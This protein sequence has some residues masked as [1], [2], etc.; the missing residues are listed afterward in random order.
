MKKQ[1]ISLAALLMSALCLGACTSDTPSASGDSSTGTDNQEQQTLVVW[2]RGTADAMEGKCF[3]SD[4]E[5]FQKEHENVTVEHLILST[6]DQVAKWNTAFASGTDPDVMDIGVSHIVSR[7][8]LGQITPLD[9]FFENW[10][11]KDNLL[12]SMVEYGRYDD[13]IYSLAYN[14]SPSVMA[15]RKDYFEAAG[16]DPEKAPKDWAE[17]LEYCEALTIYDGDVMKQGAV[18]LPSTYNSTILWQFMIQNNAETLTYENNTPDFNQE[19]VIEAFQFLSDIVP[20][21]MLGEKDN[22]F[23]T[24]VNGQTAMCLQIAPATIISM[25]E[26]DPSLKDK[27][28]YQAS[29]TNKEGGIHCGAWTYA[30]TERC[31]NKDLAWS[32]IDFV[33][34]EERCTARM[35]EQGMV[36]PLASLQDV[37]QEFGGEYG[38]LYVTQLG[39]LKQSQAYPK[40]SW[41][42]AYEE[43]LRSTYDWL[44]YG[45]KS[46]EQA[47]ADAT[48]ECLNKI[49]FCQV[50]LAADHPIGH[51]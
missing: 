49:H 46:A 10:D 13:H 6:E 42:N 37:Y 50:G 40:V 1:L 3:L 48:Q 11:N 8:E 9:E 21:A 26:E 47:A 29:L 15:W 4:V 28:G 34:S 30:I 23:S 43:T 19:P 14:A 5:A 51:K 20:Y 44:V 17:F 24:F 32:W 22:T 35:E 18:S 33:F 27:I 36:P 45:E 41:S 31:K 39:N 16:L 7:V 2:S 25:I 38:D 12:P